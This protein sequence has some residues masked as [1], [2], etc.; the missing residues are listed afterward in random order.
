MPWT[1]MELVQES[2]SLYQLRTIVHARDARRRSPILLLGT[3]ES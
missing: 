1:P 3:Y 2:R